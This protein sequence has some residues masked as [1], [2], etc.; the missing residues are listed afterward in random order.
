MKNFKNLF[1][2]SFLAIGALSTTFFTSCNPDP[3]K[4]VVCNNGGVCDEI[5]G[6][7][8]CPSG[9]EG[10]SCDTRTKTK[11]L[12]TYKGNGSN[13]HSGTYSNWSLVVGETDTTNATSATFTLKNDMNV[14]QF[15]FTGNISA[16][17][18][19]S[20]NNITV[21]NF[22]YYSGTGTIISNNS[23][24]IYFYEDSVQGTLDPYYYTFA[25]M[26]KQ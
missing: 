13:D 20:L 12:G 6:T 23:A 4:D 2:A 26:I 17:G 3:C 8:S 22:K 14:Q 10:A 24:S 16:T 18:A 9:Y 25:N 1:V 7:C 21:G 19:V 15:Q 11:Y 5:T